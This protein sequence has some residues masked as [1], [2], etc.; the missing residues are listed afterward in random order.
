MAELHR[1]FP[2]LADL[3]VI[4]LGGFSAFWLGVDPHP[5]HVTVVNLDTDDPPVEWIDAV[6][7]D[8]C[9][10][11]GPSADLV[12]SNSLI[13]HVGGYSRRQS[14]AANVARLAPRYWVQTP[15]RYF[16]VEPHWLFPGFQF[17]PLWART[18]VGL[19]WNR[20]HI[21]SATRQDSRREALWV[22]LIGISE[23]Q[24]LF[25]DAHIWREKWAGLTKSI[26]AVKDR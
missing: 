21:R 18:E 7:A 3:T 5:R 24:A 26:V 2:D 6:Q 8:A 19:R 15:Y 22:E 12:V 13:E 11:A 9:T 10:Y 20:G 4:D 14:L 17:L 16:P 1:R 23:M 25:P